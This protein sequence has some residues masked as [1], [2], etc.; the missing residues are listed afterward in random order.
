MA[1]RVDEPG[2]ERATL[3]VKLEVEIVGALVGRVEQFRDLAVLIDQQAGEVA[4]VVLV[5]ERIA[6]DVVDQPAGIGRRHERLA[7][8]RG[9]GRG[10]QRKYCR[11]HDERPY[12]SLFGLSLAKPCRSGSAKRKTALRQT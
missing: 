10:E 3:P 4:N 8:A 2:D 1:V 7:L 6:V 5:V 9:S 12:A 11:S